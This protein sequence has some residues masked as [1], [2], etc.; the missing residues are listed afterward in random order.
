LA[1]AARDVHRQYFSIPL[2]GPE[3]DPLYYR[4]DRR[5]PLMG[6]GEGRSPLPFAGALAEKREFLTSEIDHPNEPLHVIP[7]VPVEPRRYQL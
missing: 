5:A 4:Y 1:R 3:P 2:G 7:P 6:A